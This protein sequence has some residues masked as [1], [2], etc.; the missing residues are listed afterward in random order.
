MFGGNSPPPSAWHDGPSPPPSP[1]PRGPPPRVAIVDAFTSGAFGGNPAACVLLQ[2]FTAF[3]PDDYC[4]AVAAEFNL[5][6]TAFA[7]RRADGPGY[8]LRWFTPT[9]E[10][11]LC[12][13]A[14]LAAAHAL[15]TEQAAVLPIS[16]HTRS[17][18]LRASRDPTGSGVI[19]LDFPAAPPSA[20]PHAALAPLTASLGAALGGV[21]GDIQWLGKAEAINDLVVVLSSEAAVRG[22][23][24]DVAA[25]AALGGRG[26]I[27]TAQALPNADYDFVSR[28]FYP[29]AGISEDHV[30]GSAHCA[31]GPFWAARLG[32]TTLRAR[33]VS[34][35]GG[36]LLVTV[37]PG[38][39]RVTLSGRAV[40]VM[41]GELVVPF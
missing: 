19:E 6:E 15:A 36:E 21:A 8:A 41:H 13:H 40:T 25:I 14:T 7:M 9:C 34:P 38:G 23:R 1:P 26:V 16:F 17:G 24:P 27:V 10:V 4:Q 12:G 32:K 5:S 30:T 18:E 11:D 3:P 22:V 20:P 33:Q 29:A 2:P 37:Q 35:R 39:A 28:C 31:L